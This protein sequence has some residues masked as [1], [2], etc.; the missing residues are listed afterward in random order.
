MKTILL[1]GQCGSGKTWAMTEL[2]KLYNTKK[3]KIGLNGFRIDEDKKIIIIG[4]YD[5]SVFQGSDKLS[6]AVMSDSD[7]LKSVQNKYNFK[8]I[9]EGDRFTN[10]TFIN[11]FNPYIIKINDN[12]KQGRD[13]RNSTQSERHL[14]AIESRVN[15]IK[16]NILVKNSLE[17]LD[18][19][20]KIIGYEKN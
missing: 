15:N 4:V 2:L 14:K 3:A 5:G 11:K 18:L 20:K 19:I 13:K 8:I 9:A 6:M 12:G 1:I 7:K 17:A 10:S 16:E